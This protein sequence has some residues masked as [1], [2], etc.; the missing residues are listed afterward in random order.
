MTSTSEERREVAWMLRAEVS[1]DESL[2]YPVCRIINDV[3]GVNG[4]FG[5][6]A[7]RI[8]ADLMD[9]TCQMKCIPESSYRACS[10]CGAFVRQDAA[11]DCTEEIPVRFCPNCGARVIAG[12]EG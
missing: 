1:E 6:K 12:G 9:P 5:A 11:T 8:L 2:D 7:A 10:R 4:A 3:L